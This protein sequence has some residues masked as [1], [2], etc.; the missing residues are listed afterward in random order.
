MR[1]QL[2]RWS[3]PV[4]SLL[5]ITDDAGTLRGLEFAS[6]EARMHRLLRLHYGDYTLRDGAAPASITKALKAY[7]DGDMD[8]L[9]D[10]Q[11][12]TNGTVFQRSVWKVL[13]DIP[14][15]TTMSYGRLAAKLGRPSASRAVGAANGANP[16]A[17]VVPCHRVIGAS[18]ALTGYASGLP[19]KQWLLEHERRFAPALAEV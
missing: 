18:G 9:A 15:G 14:G 19:H 4:S 17:I 6:H 5:L 11:V 2:E 12:A 10:I 13:R 1:L 8:A 7:F 3:S 16:I